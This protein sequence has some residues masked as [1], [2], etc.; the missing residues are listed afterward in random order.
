MADEAVFFEKTPVRIKSCV[1]KG[2]ASLT[3]SGEV[4]RPLGT[5]DNSPPFPGW[6]S[7]RSISPV[8]IGT[9]DYQQKRQIFLKWQ[10]LKERLSPLGATPGFFF[11][12]YFYGPLLRSLRRSSG[13]KSTL[14]VSLGTA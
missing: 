1:N 2:S 9:T 8:P 11:R 13:L 10:S 14:T 6:V 12:L 4:L 3:D 7:G 5:P